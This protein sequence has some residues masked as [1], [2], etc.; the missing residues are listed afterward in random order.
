[1]AEVLPGGSRESQ[2]G[3]GSFSAINTAASVPSDSSRAG[4][5]SLPYRRGAVMAKKPPAQKLSDSKIED[6]LRRTILPIPDIR[7]VGFTTYDA[8]DPE[9]K[10]PPIRDLRPPKG[11]P[12]VLIVLIDDAGFGSSSAFGGPCHTPNAEQ[13]AAGGLMYNRF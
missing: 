1:M 12:N 4:I 9:T 7:P 8:K 11:A 10:F 3:D 6:N 13:L 2:V 5:R